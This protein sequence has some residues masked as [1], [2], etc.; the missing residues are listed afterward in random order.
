MLLEDDAAGL[1]AR[2]GV[3]VWAA[4]LS[5]RDADDLAAQ[6][7]GLPADTGAIFLTH[8]SPARARVAAHAV[9]ETGGPPVLT[10]AETT[11]ITLTAALLT[12]LADRRDRPDRCHHPTSQMGAQ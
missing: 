9:Y 4:P 11:T 8:T 7:R 12:T 3:P 2:A 10:D 1:S 6:L 5:A